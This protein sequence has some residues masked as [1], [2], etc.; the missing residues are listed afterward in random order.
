MAIWLDTHWVPLC[1]ALVFAIG[2]VWVVGLFLF[3]RKP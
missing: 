3:G 2:A 1:G